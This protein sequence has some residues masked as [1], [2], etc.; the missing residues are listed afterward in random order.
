MARTS[1]ARTVV[2]TY[3]DAI[4]FDKDNNK[5]EGTIMLFGD[6]DLTTAQNAVKHQLGARGCLVQEVRHKSY[7]GTVTFEQFDEICTKKNFKEW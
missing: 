2:K 5:R 4:W 1:F 7:F 6:Y 3:C